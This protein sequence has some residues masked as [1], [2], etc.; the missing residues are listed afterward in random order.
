[1]R[2]MGGVGED[3]LPLTSKTCS[4][5]R[6]GETVGQKRLEGGEEDN[7]KG[8]EGKTKQNTVQKVSEQQA[9]HLQSSAPRDGTASCGPKAG[10]N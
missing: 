9:S 4:Y 7:D 3:F 8:L 1:M 6:W 10:R 5:Q 2:R